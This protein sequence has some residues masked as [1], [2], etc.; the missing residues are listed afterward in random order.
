MDDDKKLQD[1]ISEGLRNAQQ[2]DA[3]RYA[4][5]MLF[6]KV[7]ELLKTY[8]S[9]ANTLIERRQKRRM[10]LSEFTGSYFHLDPQKATWARTEIDSV[11]N[12]TDPRES[13][14]RIMDRIRVADE[15]DRPRLRRLFLE[16][17]DGAFSLE[18]PFTLEWLQSIIQFSPEFIRA[19]DQVVVFLFPTENLDRLRRLVVHALEATS[20]EERIVLF[21]GTI[22]TATD[23]TLLCEVFRAVAGDKNPSGSTKYHKP[24]TLGN[25]TE[26]V[27]EILLTK[28]RYFAE[29]GEIWTQAD[30]LHVLWCWWS[31]VISAEVPEFIGRAIGDPTGLRTLLHITVSLVR[32]S[33]G[34]YEQVSR[35]MW[36]KIVDLELLKKLA[37]D[38]LA[39]GTENDRT[40]AQRFLSALK[41]SNRR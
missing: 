38:L 16:Q 36:S 32:S 10:S 37:N 5:A 1:K 41:N 11:L 2:S 24:A 3:A 23:I 21:K 9:R 8:V 35:E 4:L 17:L 15:R 29:S 25:E 26:P 33:D 18:R 28:I 6:P 7:G 22:S 39:K 40:L 27:R 30:P 31:S 13:L 20:L 19:R 14:K 12:Q 34:N